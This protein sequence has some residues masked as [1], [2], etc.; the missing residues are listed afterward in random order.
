MGDLRSAIRR[1]RERR[2]RWRRDRERSIGQHL[3]I[4]GAIGWLIVVPALLGALAGRWLDARLDT[5]V[6]FSA[7]LL[8]LGI[9]LGCTMAWRAVRERGEP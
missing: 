8:V 9:A 7:G 1:A 6:T 5:G 4:A 3:A 2:R